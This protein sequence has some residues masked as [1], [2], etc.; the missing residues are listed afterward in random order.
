MLEKFVYIIKL[1]KKILKHNIIITKIVYYN[2]LN[3]N[4]KMFSLF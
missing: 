3:I 2:A 4:K 1:K